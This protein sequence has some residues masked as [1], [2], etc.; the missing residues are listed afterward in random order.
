MLKRISEYLMMKWLQDGWKFL[1]G[2]VLVLAV[3][4]MVH[5]P[6]TAWLHDSGS[7][8]YHYS[9]EILLLA[10]IGTVTCLGFIGMIIQVLVL[11]PKSNKLSFKRK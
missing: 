8:L 9:W 7:P 6:F 11:S 1:V 2:L 3:A 10:A 5:G 4:T